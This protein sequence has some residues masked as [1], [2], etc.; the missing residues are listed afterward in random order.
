M[1]KCGLHFAGYGEFEKLDGSCKAR[2]MEYEGILWHIFQLALHPVRSKCTLFYKTKILSR[3]RQDFRF[4]FYILKFSVFVVHDRIFEMNTEWLRL[5]LLSDRSKT[6]FAAGFVSC[7]V[8]ALDNTQSILCGWRLVW[9]K[10]ISR[11]FVCFLSDNGIRA[12][13]CVWC[14]IPY[15]C[16]ERR[17]VVWNSTVL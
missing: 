14:S 7:F 17:Q 6:I 4:V 10:S 8:L 1:E 13:Y 5:I 15:S 16:S 11:I 3:Q 2:S 12:G 9:P